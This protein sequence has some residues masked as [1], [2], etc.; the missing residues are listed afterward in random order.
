M[1]DLEIGMTINYNSHTLKVEKA[2]DDSNPCKGC[3][4]D[5]FL[6]CTKDTNKYGRCNHFDREDKTDVIFKEIK[7]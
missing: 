6:D 5:N 3:I 1:K 2:I 7:S 4:F